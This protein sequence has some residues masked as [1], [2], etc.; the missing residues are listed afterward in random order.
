M[1]LNRDEYRRMTTFE[2][3]SL[4]EAVEFSRDTHG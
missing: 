3:L 1:A 2:D 4:G